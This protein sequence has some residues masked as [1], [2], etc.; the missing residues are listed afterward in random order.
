[1]KKKS[2]HSYT[3]AESIDAKNCQN[4]KEKPFPEDGIGNKNHGKMTV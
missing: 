4:I 3:G 2:H 1:M